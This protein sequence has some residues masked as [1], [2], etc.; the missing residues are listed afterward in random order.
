MLSLLLRMLPPDLS[1]APALVGP[2]LETLAI[3]LW[4][5]TLGA[6]IALPLGIGAARNM[7]PHRALYAVARLTLNMQRGISELVWAL[8]FVAAVGLGAFPGVVALAVHSAGQLG[9][10]YAEAIENVDPGPIEALLATGANRVQTFAYAVWPQI[11]PEVISYTLYRWEVD[12]RSAFVLGL[13]GAGGL[14]FE[15]QMAL[16]LFRYQEAL[17]I[18]VV[19]V[20]VVTAIDWLSSRIRARVI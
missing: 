19:I 15:L 16:R 14:G 8:L 3:A 11:L 17:A 2:T 1:Y 7:T 9:K 13:V 5:T 10:F 18:L 20:A 4:G 12:V 6:C